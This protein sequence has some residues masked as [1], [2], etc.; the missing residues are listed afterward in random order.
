MTGSETRVLSRT[1]AVLLAVS[2][3][4]YGW[5]ARPGAPALAAGP[6]QGPALLEESVRLRAEGE[7]RA[8]PLAPGERI[9]PNR[10]PEEEIDRL[11]GLGPGAARALVAARAAEGPFRTPEDLLRVRGIGPATLARVRDH[12]DLSD[13]PPRAARRV[14]SVG[15]PAAGRGTPLTAAVPGPRAGAEAPRAGPLDL[16]RATAAQL[17]SLPGIGPAL[18]ARILEAR[19]RRGGFGRAEDLLEVRGI[20]PATLERLRPRVRVGGG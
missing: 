12:L 2:L 14:G 20:G 18:A 3:V 17:E 16:N 15:P 9:D 6:D 5:E 7:R 1:A 13:P 19:A 10:A 8:R 11:P 4:R